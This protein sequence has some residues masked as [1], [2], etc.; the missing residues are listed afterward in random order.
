[1]PINIQEIELANASDPVQI[2]AGYSR[3]RILLKQDSIPLAWVDLSRNDSDGC[4]EQQKSLI[5][6]SLDLDRV[7]SYVM[8]QPKRVDNHAEKTISLPPITV[9]VCTRNRSRW[10]DSCLHSIYNLIYPSFEVLVVDNA[11]DDHSTHEIARKY[12][13]RYVCED[14]PGLDW[15]RNR[16]IESATHE[17][18]AFTD[19]DARV[20]PHWLSFIAAAFKDPEIDCV[21]GFVGPAELRTNAQKIFELAYGGMGHGFKKKR[22]HRRDLS[23]K[24]LLWASGYGVGANMAFRKNVFNEIGQFDPALDV[25]TP[26]G[27][28]GDVEMFHRL[29]VKGKTLLYEPAVLVWHTHRADMKALQTQIF[30]NGRSFGC[31][32]MTCIYNRTVPK[33]RVFH[34]FLVH[35][36][37][38]WIFK[39]LRRPP[40]LLSRKL[41]I[42]ELFGMVSSPWAYYQSKRYAEKLKRNDYKKQIPEWELAAEKAGL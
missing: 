21:T 2:P 10:L 38:Q 32:L 40:K 3:A 34:F 36:L 30:Q 4:L 18:L 12:G 1:M 37:Y 15:A 11:P 24:Q 22:V 19:D 17:I 27:G 7:N 33:S 25:G 8:G 42:T 23:A 31:Y 26:S 39:N 35:W 20:D 9:I 29:L 28:G 41:V 5:R 16:G 6:K 13:A 14:K